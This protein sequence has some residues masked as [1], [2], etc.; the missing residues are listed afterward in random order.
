MRTY[1]T[2]VGEKQYWRLSICHWWYSLNCPWCSGSACQGTR[3]LNPKK[4]KWWSKLKWWDSYR[5]N[6]SHGNKAFL[7]A[8]HC[9]WTPLVRA[10]WPSLCCSILGWDRSG[11]KSWETSILYSLARL[12]SGFLKQ[13]MLPFELPVAFLRCEVLVLTRSAFPGDVPRSKR[14]TLL[15]YSGQRAQ[16]FGFV[17]PLS[18]SAEL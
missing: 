12:S 13:A 11:E 2:L 1:L 4:G 16:C 17:F 7:L 10:P 3:T 5:K 14:Q 15:N 8:S 9:H 6:C 18:E